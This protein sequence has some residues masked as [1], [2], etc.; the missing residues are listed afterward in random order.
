MP[1]GK[2]VKSIPGA[3][4]VLAGAGLLTATAFTNAPSGPNDFFWHISFVVG[5][6]SARVG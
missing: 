4:T 2:H 1:R 6:P 3:I 5:L